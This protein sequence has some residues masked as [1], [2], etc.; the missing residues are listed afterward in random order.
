MLLCILCGF[1]FIFG[2][3][4]R[5]FI[6]FF[7]RFLLSF[8]LLC[9]LGICRQQVFIKYYAVCLFFVFGFFFLVLDV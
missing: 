4:Q 8:F 7:I 6:I 2:C 3:V 1:L 9:S 5:F